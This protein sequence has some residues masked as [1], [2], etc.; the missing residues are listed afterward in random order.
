MKSLIT[1]TALLAVF[2]ANSFAND[3]NSMLTDSDFQKIEIKLSA[4]AENIRN[5]ER[6]GILTQLCNDNPYPNSCLVLGL[7]QVGMVMQIC[8]SKPTCMERT[9][10]YKRKVEKFTLKYTQHAG[11]GRMALNICSPLFVVV[12]NNEKG[13]ALETLL[14]DVADLGLFY[15]YEPL[16]KCIVDTYKKKTTQ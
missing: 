13:K 1:A 14:N 2:T 15:D 9:L 11:Y 7:Y 10:E 4:E 8:D 16:Y 3:D 6:M 5:N 12:S